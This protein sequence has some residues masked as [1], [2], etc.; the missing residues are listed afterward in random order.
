M[1]EWEE[2]EVLVME[3]EEEEELMKKE[4]EEE[5][6]VGMVTVTVTVSVVGWWKEMGGRRVA[7]ME[8]GLR[9]MITKSSTGQARLDYINRFLRVSLHHLCLSRSG[10]F[11]G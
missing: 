11:E 9:R 3:E 8:A 2:Q 1:E 5:E 7:A 6:V 4:K 10:F